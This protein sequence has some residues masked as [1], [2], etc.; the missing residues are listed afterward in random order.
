MTEPGLGVEEGFDEAAL[1]FESRS[2]T[3]PQSEKAQII[4][5]IW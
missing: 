3:M 2:S 1:K 5:I 4:Q